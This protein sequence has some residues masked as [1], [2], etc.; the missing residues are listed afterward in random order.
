M[1]D[2]VM[3]RYLSEVAYPTGEESRIVIDPS[4]SSAAVRIVTEFLATLTVEELDQL[5]VI[6]HQRLTDQ[7][8]YKREC[9]RK[10]LLPL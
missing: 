5:A 8:A 9:A 10:G 6:T 4:V 2:V 1:G 7:R 3:T